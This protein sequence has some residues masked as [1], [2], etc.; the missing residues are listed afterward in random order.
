MAQGK[1][2]W[3][4]KMA[5]RL[6]RRIADEPTDEQVDEAYTLV[7]RLCRLASDNERNTERDNDARWWQGDRFQRMHERNSARWAEREKEIRALFGKY[8]C[9]IDW[10]GVYPC[11]NA[12]EGGT[13]DI[14]EMW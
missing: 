2:F 7:N 8:G 6:A 3:R 4:R 5:E 9:H 13:I 1:R 12:D 11:I 10:P 14:W